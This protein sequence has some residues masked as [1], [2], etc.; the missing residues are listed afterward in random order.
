MISKLPVIGPALM[1]KDLCAVLLPRQE[2]RR[3]F[4]A[5][6][7]PLTGHR[8][9]Y[10]ADSGLSAFYLI[11][12][13]LSRGSE[14]NEVVLP[15]YT[16]GSLM[17]AVRAAGLVPVLCDVSLRD[18][19]L[20]LS[21]LG[22]A[23]T[24]RTL[25]VT[26]CHMFGIPIEGVGQLSSRFPGVYLIEDCAQ[27][28]GSEVGGAPVG[29]SG[30]ISFYSFNRGKNLPLSG[31]GCI[32]VSPEGKAGRIEFPVLE[33]KRS[34]LAA[35]WRSAAFYAAA[36]PFVYGAAYALIS[37]FK[38]SAPPLGVCPADMADLSVRL[39]ERLLPRCG[40]LW[41][42]RYERGNVLLKG[43]S[44]IH[45]LR[46][47]QIPPGS[48]PAFN[49][50]PVMFDDPV[51]AEAARRRLW[52]AGIESSRMYLEPL[53]RM[54]DP[55][56]AADSFPNARRLAAGMLALPCHPGCSL[57]DME[58]MVKVLSV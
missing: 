44:G 6:L 42:A 7:G 33:A 57:A 48:R 55:G 54:F 26:C 5:G 38:E 49:R 1:P 3:R 17:V 37:R 58:T 24:S 39:G 51:A 35:W 47:P 30:D 31:G 4:C 15:A 21:L 45:G 40:E 23:V 32:A 22:Q 9:L 10:L 12:K 27:S 41:R 20:D 50:F 16:A 13:A 43:L 14:R 11:L 36:R 8:R 28:M 19:N 25:A 2:G 29:L 52:R 34:S 18:F 56:A 53:H 46:L